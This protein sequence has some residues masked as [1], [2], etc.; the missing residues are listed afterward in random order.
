MIAQTIQRMMA[1]VLGPPNESRL[2]CGRRA[3]RRKAAVPEPANAGEGTVD[4]LKKQA[5]QL[6][7]HVRLRLVL[8][9]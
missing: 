6:Q 7:A 8:R 2:S 9:S 3:R 4:S 5:R 1:Y